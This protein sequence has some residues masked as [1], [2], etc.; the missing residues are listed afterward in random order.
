TRGYTAAVRSAIRHAVVSF[1]IFGAL[2]FAMYRLA[3]T[4]PTGFIPQED[5]GY[6]FTVVQLPDGASLDRTDKVIREAE[7]F[8]LSHPAVQNV[9]A[10]GGFD[11]LSGGTNATNAG[12]MFVSLKPFDQRTGP[13]LSAD[14]VIA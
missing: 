8:Y 11:L 7:R 9:V 5:Q 3:T 13:G 6:V 4:I 14:A 1:L 2:C 12:V 10:L